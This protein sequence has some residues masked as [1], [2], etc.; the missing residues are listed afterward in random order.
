MKKALCFLL[1]IIF[2]ACVIGYGSSERF[3]LLVMIENLTNFDDMPTVEDIG[4]VWTSPW[5]YKEGVLT[6]PYWV[7]FY[8]LIDSSV[9]GD[10][11]ALFYEMPLALTED[12]QR[13]ERYKDDD[14]DYR[15]VK[16]PSNNV[17]GWEYLWGITLDNGEYLRFDENE[18]GEP[19]VPV[20]DGWREAYNGYEGDN[21]VIEF[22]CNIKAFFLRLW[23]TCELIIK[24]LI[25]VLSNL[26][27]LLPWNST[28]PRG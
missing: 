8:P 20:V 14:I 17:V 11:L 1:A 27:Y 4:N 13:D 7:T 2:V 15:V 12:G 24:M 5:Y 10:K 9:A 3:S 26:Q 25:C 28:V 6:L 22:F 16:V 19:V 18:N 21:A 23:N